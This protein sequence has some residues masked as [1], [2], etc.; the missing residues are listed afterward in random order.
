MPKPS[1]KSKNIK[2]D[3][4]RDLWR[5][6]TKLSTALSS[7]VT[8]AGDGDLAVDGADR[9]GFGTWA[10]EKRKLER[11]LVLLRSRNTFLERNRDRGRLTFRCTAASGRDGAL[12]I[13]W[14]STIE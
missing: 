3:I 7:L 10:E 9:S 4:V 6:Y 2:G 1:E 12:G 14:D 5:A 8:R 13:V 11:E